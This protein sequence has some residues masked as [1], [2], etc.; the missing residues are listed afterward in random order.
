MGLILH[1]ESFSAAGL[2]SSLDVFAPLGHIWI[3]W[4]DNAAE[5]TE[6]GFSDFT[7]L[8]KDQIY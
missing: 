8:Q 7:A 3:R 4:E 6:Q 5:E 2:M 1:Q